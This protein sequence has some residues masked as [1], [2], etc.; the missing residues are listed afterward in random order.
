QTGTVHGSTWQRGVQWTVWHKIAPA[1]A[2]AYAPALRVVT[3]RVL[4][5]LHDLA[6]PDDAVRDILVA[7]PPD[8]LTA[9]TRHYP[10]VYLQDGQNLFDPRTSFAGDW[11]LLETL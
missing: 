10:V 2:A 9:P 11:H 5:T 3:C 6:G 1:R 7:T 8:Y 4:H